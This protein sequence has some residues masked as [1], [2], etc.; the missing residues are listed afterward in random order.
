MISHAHA[1]SGLMLRLSTARLPSL[2]SPTSFWAYRAQRA[3]TSGDAGAIESLS[4]LPTCFP[5][6]FQVP[7]PGG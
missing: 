5:G 2:L 1:Q 4:H 6:G 7:S 3:K